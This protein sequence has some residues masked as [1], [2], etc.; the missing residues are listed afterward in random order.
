MLGAIAFA[1]SALPDLPKLTDVEAKISQLEGIELI[2]EMVSP[3]VVPVR[4]KV[5]PNNRFWS[6]YP[7]SERFVIGK[8]VTT[9]MPDRREFAT[10]PEDS[11]NPLPVGYHSLWKGTS[12]YKQVGETTEAKFH[13]FD[14]YMIPCQV[15]DAYTIQLY[16]EKA[17]LL[18]RGT[19]VEFGGKTHEMV[20]NT[21][22]IRKL[23]DAWLEFRKPAD[24]R[25]AGKF[26]PLSSL[27][28]PGTKLANVKAADITG[29]KVELSQLLKKHSGLVVNFW[30]SSCTG[31]VAEMPFL[32]KLH[33]KLKAANIGLVGVNAVDAKG[34]AGR[35]SSTII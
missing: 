12:P 5:S 13:G 34:Y 9:W 26:D 18:P 28:K 23:D 30:F 16:V 31:C 22:N 29:S 21:I 3:S 14:C 6:K 25:V 10:E 2:S 1:F 32:V 8:M 17:S 27:I 15:T 4:F 35:T 20:H 11:G 24:A 33:P 19:K 7:T